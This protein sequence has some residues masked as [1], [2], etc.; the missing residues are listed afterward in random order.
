MVVIEHK[1]I[2][3]TLVKLTVSVHYKASFVLHT[4]LI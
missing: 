4:T 3:R 1:Y 2:V